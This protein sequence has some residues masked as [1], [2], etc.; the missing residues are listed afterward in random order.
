ME[1][2]IEIDREIEREGS[3]TSDILKHRNIQLGN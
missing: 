3:G 1:M 2:E